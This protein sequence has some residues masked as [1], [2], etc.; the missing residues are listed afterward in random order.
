MKDLVICENW[1]SALYAPADFGAQKIVPFV[2]EEM[3]K[4]NLKSVLFEAQ[5]ADT[6]KA[7]KTVLEE[8]R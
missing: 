1:R 3:K 5:K 8:Y 4:L 2:Q 7:L 6:K